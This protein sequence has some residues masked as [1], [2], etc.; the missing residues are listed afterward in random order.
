MFTRL[1]T[2]TKVSRRTK[3]LE[4]HNNLCRLSII[5]G[6]LIA[7]CFKARFIEAPRRDALPSRRLMW[8][9]ASSLEKMMFLWTIVSFHNDIRLSTAKGNMRCDRV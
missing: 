6:Y 3:M 1:L 9:A 2:D 7:R 8:R 4:F 5:S